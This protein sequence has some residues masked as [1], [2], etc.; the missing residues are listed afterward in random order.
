MSSVRASHDA[1]YVVAG[2]AFLSDRSG[3]VSGQSF[4]FEMKRQDAPV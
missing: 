3:L 2:G 4:E 1:E